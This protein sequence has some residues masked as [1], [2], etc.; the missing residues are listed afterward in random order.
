VVI[1]S[2]LFIIVLLPIGRLY[3][4]IAVVALQ[5]G[6]LPVNID[7]DHVPVW[8]KTGGERRKFAN[9]RGGERKVF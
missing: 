9:S 3:Y 7:A 5:G 2:L 1:S 6:G 8:G 4:L